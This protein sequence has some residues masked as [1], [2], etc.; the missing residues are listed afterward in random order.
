MAT[1]IPPAGAPCER[2]LSAPKHRSHRTVFPA[3][4]C[5][6]N[7]AGRNSGVAALAQHAPKQFGR[8]AR[9][10]LAYEAG[11]RAFEGA[12]P[13]AELARGFLVG[14]ADRDPR[15]HLTLPR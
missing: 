3:A 7:S 12:R 11:A 9:A 15:Q 10:D 8:V 5:A 4:T 1:K 2:N 14:L 13:K 6:N